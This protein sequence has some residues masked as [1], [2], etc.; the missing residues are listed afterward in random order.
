[1]FDRGRRS[2]ELIEAKPV[3]KMRRFC[4]SGFAGCSR[5]AVVYVL[6]LGLFGTLSTGCGNTSSRTRDDGHGYA[7]RSDRSG[8]EEIPPDDRRVIIERPDEKRTYR[9]SSRDEPTTR[10]ESSR[11][12][13][14][15]PPPVEEPAP[16]RPEGIRIYEVRPGDTLWKISD[17]FYG[18][19]RH[20]RR[21]YSANRN[22]VGDPRE[23]PVGI[24]LIIP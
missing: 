20:W 13:P 15:T 6:A 5:H 24:K 19:S 11:T 14:P 8:A 7:G 3:M 17:R 21:I 4:H 1:V 9:I 22:R 18:H 16:A 2:L 23:L 12:T 10:D